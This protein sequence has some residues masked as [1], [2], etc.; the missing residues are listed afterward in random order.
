MPWWQA[1]LAWSSLGSP[2]NVHGVIKC[3]ALSEFSVFY[4]SNPHNVSLSLLYV[5]L[6]AWNWVW[7]NRS[8]CLFAGIVQRSVE[9]QSPCPHDHDSGQEARAHDSVLTLNVPNKA[10]CRSLPRRVK[11]SI[12]LEVLQSSTLCVWSF[13]TPSDNHSPFLTLWLGGKAKQ[14]K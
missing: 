14:R 11:K 5:T 13:S 8:R 2:T 7:D 3:G 1:V 4:V 6:E 10:Q 12:H 9:S